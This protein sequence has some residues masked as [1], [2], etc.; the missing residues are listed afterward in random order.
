M[1]SCLH[2][3]ELSTYALHDVAIDSAI[4]VEQPVDGALRLHGIELS[5]YEVH[6]IELGAAAGT[7]DQHVHDVTFC[8]SRMWPEIVTVDG[9][10][11]VVNGEPV[12]VLV[13]G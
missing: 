11:L 2:D 10:P 9:V 5:T 6:D 13:E 12:W 3:V 1:D 4:E 8:K 7:F